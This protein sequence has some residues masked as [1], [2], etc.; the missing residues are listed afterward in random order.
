MMTRLCAFI[1][2]GVASLLLAAG[3]ASVPD[4]PKERGNALAESFYVVAPWAQQPPVDITARL[5]AVN[6]ALAGLHASIDS[7]YAGVR[8]QADAHNSRVFLQAELAASREAQRRR[9][10]AARP[11]PPQAD[12]DWRDRKPAT[13]D[14]KRIAPYRENAP[15]WMG[16][17]AGTAVVGFAQGWEGWM[18][19]RMRDAVRLPGGR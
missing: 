19:G 16:F 12:P 7:Y 2:A 4:A 1:P 17:E 5:G 6:A 14:S 15:P 8:A 10:L 18:H 11:A 3:C 9:E 13:I